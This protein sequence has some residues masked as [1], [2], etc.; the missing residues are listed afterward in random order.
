VYNSIGNSIQIQNKA[1]G[2]QAW[3][4][5]FTDIDLVKFYCITRASSNDFIKKFEEV[6]L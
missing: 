5:H 2:L 3:F 4:I 6:L 1:P